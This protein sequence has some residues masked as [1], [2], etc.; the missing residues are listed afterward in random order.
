M[1]LNKKETENYWV[2][3][4]PEGRRDPNQNFKKLQN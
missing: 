3:R 4:V 1:T 2:N